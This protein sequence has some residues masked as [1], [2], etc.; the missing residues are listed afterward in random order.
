MAINVF[1]RTYGLI[2]RTE[3]DDSLAVSHWAVIDLLE[4]QRLLQDFQYWQSKDQRRLLHFLQQ[5]DAKRVQTQAGCW[6]ATV[7]AYTHSLISSL[8]YIMSITLISIGDGVP[9]FCLRDFCGSRESSP[10]ASEVLYPS[11]EA[12]DDEKAEDEAVD[13]GFW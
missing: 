1:R 2:L 5:L 7:Y 10:S 6:A 9:V 8:R 4:V 13:S 12:S 11:E 3:R